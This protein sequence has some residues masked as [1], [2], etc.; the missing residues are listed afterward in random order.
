MSAATRFAI[1]MGSGVFPPH[2]HSTLRSTAFALVEGIAFDGSHGTL[3]NRRVFAHFDGSEGLP[4]GICS[5]AEGGLWIAHWDGAC[6]TRYGADGKR[7]HKVELPAPRVTCPIFGGPDLKT[8]F[9]TTSG[10]QVIDKAPLSGS[11]F[12][13]E[14]AVPGRPI[15]AFKG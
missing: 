5:D 2:S 6:V 9:I 1:K 13:F 15:A 7:T 8:L 4:D 14:P 3:S 10:D 12:A 11:I